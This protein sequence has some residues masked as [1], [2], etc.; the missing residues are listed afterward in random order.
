MRLTDAYR[1][2][3]I[4]EIR[5]RARNVWDPSEASFHSRGA[6]SHAFQ[7]VAFRLG[8]EADQLD[9]RRMW[10][11]WARAFYD[12]K[13][14]RLKRKPKYHRE[15]CFLADLSMDQLHAVAMTF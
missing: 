2:R 3:I 13:M 11:R 9:I 5:D 1:K 14:Q 8:G 10:F 12:Y 15:L 4:A 6:R 7:G